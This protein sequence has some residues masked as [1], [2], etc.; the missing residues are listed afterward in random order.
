MLFTTLTTSSFFAASVLA[1]AQPQPYLLPR[2]GDTPDISINPSFGLVV[3]Q[4]NGY[5]PTHGPTCTGAGDTCETA[6]GP[7]YLQCPS[8]TG[9]HCFDTA[10]KQICCSDGNGCEFFPLNPFSTSLTPPQMLATTAI[11]AQKLSP[12]K[13][14]AAR[15]GWT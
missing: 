8:T 9:I 13:H 1:I 14:G 5:Q 3:R 7:T 10:I 15:T 11:I 12:S 2:G 6:C 4:A